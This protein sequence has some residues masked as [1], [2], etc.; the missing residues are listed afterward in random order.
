MRISFKMAMAA[1]DEPAIMAHVTSGA[2]T[3]P[4]TIPSSWG[5]SESKQQW[6]RAEPS[7]GPQSKDELIKQL[8]SENSTLTWI[9]RFV[10][11]LC[12]WA[13]VYC[14]LQPI[15]A[16][17]DIIG[18]YLRMLPCGSFLE[19][20]LEGA[21]HELL[22]CLACGVGC[23]CALFVISIMWVAMRPLV[24]IPLMILALCCFVGGV[25]TFKSQH[26]GKAKGQPADEE[27]GED[28][29]E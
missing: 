6:I 28:Y 24:G 27:E 14:C 15:S 23:S 21:V 11:A 22:C 2:L 5:C 18:D 20:C 9:L 8:Q 29:S 12:A 4:E 26:K 7:T 3:G 19:D 1:N 13:S 10:G 17:A 25:G 16:A